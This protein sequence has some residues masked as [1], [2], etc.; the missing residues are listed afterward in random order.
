ME[1][2]VGSQISSVCLWLSSA[3]TTV[4]HQDF[5]KSQ[6]FSSNSKRKEKGEESVVIWSSLWPPTGKRGC[7]GPLWP[8]QWSESIRS[9]SE[10]GR[11][12]TRWQGHGGQGGGKWIIG[13]ILYSFWGSSR[14]NHVCQLFWFHQFSKL[15][16]VFL[17]KWCNQLNWDQRHKHCLTSAKM[18]LWSQL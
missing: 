2:P 7:G 13:V 11:R 1:A 5:N 17:I 14:L 8:P 3:D 12:V 4:F 15:M 18:F 9:G 16:L 6:H 10:E